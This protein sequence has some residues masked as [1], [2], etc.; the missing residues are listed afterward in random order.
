MH[1]LGSPYSRCTAGA[2]GLDVPLLYKASY[3]MQVRLG[4]G[5]WEATGRGGRGTG[6]GGRAGKT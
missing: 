6:I 5:L 4:E 1:R 2:E 3:T